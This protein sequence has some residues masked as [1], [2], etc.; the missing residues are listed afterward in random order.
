MKTVLQSCL[1]Q[2]LIEVAR[3]AF[4]P[5]DQSLRRDTRIQ[6]R[7]YFATRVA[8]PSHYVSAPSGLASW[9]VP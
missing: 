3:Y 5:I 9:H 4:S 7:Y 6:T 1:L 8:L 2:A